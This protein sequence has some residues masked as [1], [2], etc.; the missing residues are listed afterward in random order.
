MIEVTIAC[1]TASRPT[2]RSG[3]PRRERRGRGRGVRSRAG[4]GGRPCA[5]SAARGSRGER[6]GERSAAAASA[7]AA[8]PT[9]ANVIS[10]VRGARPSKR[11]EVPVGGAQRRPTGPGRTRLV[12]AAIIRSTQDP[13]RGY[14]AEAAAAA[15]PTATGR[16]AERDG[17]DG[18]PPRPASRALGGRQDPAV[19]A[20]VGEEED[21][22]RPLDVRRC[23]RRA[24]G[25]EPALASHRASPS[26]PPVR[27]HRRSRSRRT[28]PSAG[29]SWRPSARAAR[30]CPTSATRRR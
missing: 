19:L 15:G 4:R 12:R 25:G 23:G 18:I 11:A 13:A 30:T 14:D 2:R 17:V 20:P 7:S 8:T 6:N 21:R 9:N 1:A 29:R 26:P 10:V 22:H 27:A 24:D 28:L 5:R 16:S 3:A